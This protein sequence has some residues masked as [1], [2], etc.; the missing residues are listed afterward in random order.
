LSLIE[1]DAMEFSTRHGKRQCAD[2]NAADDQ[3]SAVKVRLANLV[4]E[5]E[6]RDVENRSVR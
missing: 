5:P 1:Y 4:R 3:F 2:R 6:V